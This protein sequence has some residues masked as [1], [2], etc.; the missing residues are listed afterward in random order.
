MRIAPSQRQQRGAV[1]ILFFLALFLSGATVVLSALNNRTNNIARGVETQVAMDAAKEALLT[2]ALMY[3]TEY[4]GSGPGRLPCAD[5][6]NDGL[7]N[8]VAA[9]LGRLPREVILPSGARFPLSDAGSGLDQ[10]LWYA[11]S[12]SFRSTAAIVNSSTAGIMTLDGESGIVAVLLAPGPAL[13]GQTR[14]SVNANR[15]LEDANTT[16]PD[17]VSSSALAS[18][19]DRVL[20]IR[21]DE[22]LSYVTPRVAQEIKRMLDIYHPANGNTYPA[23]AGFSGAMTAGWLVSNNWHT[24]VEQYL[25]SSP[26]NV[27]TVKF[28]NCDIVFTLTFGSAAIARSQSSC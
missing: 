11:L 26:P 23:P 25:L 8:C 14:P 28:L 7:A 24:S 10:Q 3:S 2:Y 19:N 20:P 18:F 27:A 22:L 1:I 9:Q 21:R 12:P 13:A 16:A 6:D 4:A 15:Y 17:F 5:T